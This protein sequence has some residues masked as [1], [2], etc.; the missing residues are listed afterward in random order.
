MKTL[1]KAL[2]NM[3]AT[4]DRQADVSFTYYVV[5]MALVFLAIVAI[6]GDAKL[7][8]ISVSMVA[9]FASLVAGWALA[10]YREV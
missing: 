5:S 4:G 2:S 6:M 8:L 1:A 9:G 7:L 3:L 10:F